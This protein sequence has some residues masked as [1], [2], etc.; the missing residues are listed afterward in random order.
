MTAEFPLGLTNARPSRAAL[1]QR[2]INTHLQ[3]QVLRRIIRLHKW[4]YVDSDYLW[5]PKV[6]AGMVVEGG[7]SL[8]YLAVWVLFS[9][10]NSPCPST[11]AAV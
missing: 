5:V 7:S 6:L 1:A 2:L 3:P 8:A 4:G 9:N 10:L 11:K